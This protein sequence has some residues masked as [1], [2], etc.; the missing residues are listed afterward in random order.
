MFVY[1]QGKAF[2]RW[3]L[4]SKTT[5][6]NREWREWE[7]YDDWGR[8]AK[9]KKKKGKITSWCFFFLLFSGCGLQ[10][11]ELLPGMVLP[12]WVWEWKQTYLYQ[13]KSSSSLW[14]DGDFFSYSRP[15]SRIFEGLQKQLSLSGK[16]W[17]W[18]GY[19]RPYLL[20]VEII[21]QYYNLIPA[22]LVFGAFCVSV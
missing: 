17:P 6:T 13:K 16:H 12:P 20:S 1:C 8:E 11:Q 22:L 2:G 18:A 19:L 21:Y 9:E 5:F 7:G 14:S 3:D 10:P 15:L 4:T